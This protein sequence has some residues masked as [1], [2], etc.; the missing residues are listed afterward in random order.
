MGFEGGKHV[1]S[2]QISGQLCERWWKAGNPAERGDT[3]R[4]S[5]FTAIFKVTLF[6]PPEIICIA[7]AHVLI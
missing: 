5:F 2:P 3:Q 4:L 1:L 6:Y 7:D